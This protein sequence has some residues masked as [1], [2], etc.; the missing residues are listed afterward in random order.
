MRGVAFRRG[1]GILPG[2]ETFKNS[3]TKFLPLFSALTAL[4]RPSKNLRWWS[5]TP[6]LIDLNEG[7]PP[8][9]WR[10]WH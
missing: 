2:R 10:N 1:W 9:Q 5:T 4:W 6:I 8:L 7:R 3:D